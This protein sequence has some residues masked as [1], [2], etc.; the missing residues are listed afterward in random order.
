MVLN[1]MNSICLIGTEPQVGKTFNA[2][3]LINYLRQRGANPGYFKPVALGTPSLEK[4]E[5]MLVRQQCT[6]HQELSEMTCCIYPAKASIHFS[7]RETGRYVDLEQIAQT[8]AWNIA[9]H[10][11]MI[12]ET[13]GGTVTPLILNKERVLMQDDLIKRLKIRNVILVAKAG[14]GSINHCTLSA[15][16]LRNQ[17]HNL[18]GIILNGY[19][20]TNPVHR[21]NLL[22]IEYMCQ[23]KVIAATGVNETTF[24]PRVEISYLFAEDMPEMADMAEDF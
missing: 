10:S 12:V 1:L 21:D 23:T 9:T 4:S 16:Y 13:A 22:S 6:T 5:A 17:G 2:V 24:R 15:M 7:A 18:K 8:Y 3:L 19:D 11:H 14:F 20:E